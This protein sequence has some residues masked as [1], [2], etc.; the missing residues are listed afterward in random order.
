MS[1]D[2]EK[3]I[4]EIVEKHVLTQLR[5]YEANIHLPNMLYRISGV[6]LILLGLAIPI[7]T[8]VPDATLNGHKDLVISITGLAITGLTA[9]SSFFAWDKT[10]RG[11]RLTTTDLNLAL[12][13]WEVE[14]TRSRIPSVPSDS[15]KH[16]LQATKELLQRSYSTTRA[17]TEQFF[18]DLSTPGEGKGASETDKPIT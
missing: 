15:D 8:Q 13:E 18:K 4:K 7:L 1:P 5:W 2:L 6:L 17:E 16:A 3:R 12:A 10:W 11:R 9:I 14:M